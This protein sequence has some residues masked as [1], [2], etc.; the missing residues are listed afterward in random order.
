MVEFFAGQRIWDQVPPFHATDV[1]SAAVS[2]LGANADALV[3]LGRGDRLVFDGSDAA[4]RA[5]LANPDVLERWEAAGVE[6]RSLG[7][8]HAKV[9]VVEPGGSHGHAIAYVGSLNLSHHSNDSLEEAFVVLNEQTAVAGVNNWIEGL[10]ARGEPVTPRWIKRARTLYRPPSGP[11]PRAAPHEFI[12][13]SGRAWLTTIEDSD[14]E[15]GPATT[16]AVDEVRV[17]GGTLMVDAVD[18]TDADRGQ[19]GDV[20]LVTFPRFR[21]TGRAVSGNAKV[22]G[23]CVVRRVIRE[24]GHSTDIVVWAPPDQ[25]TSPHRLSTVRAHLGLDAQTDTYLVPKR[26]VAALYTLL[27]VRRP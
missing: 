4:L 11:K 23:L 17:A 3:W 21:R 14:V 19:V 20:W 6:L 8:L 5:G 12:D 13:L 25:L 9:L 1:V 22:R 2:F 26:N 27:G 10:L 18:T 24:Q 15:F 16:R 7:G